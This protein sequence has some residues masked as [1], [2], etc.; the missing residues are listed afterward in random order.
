MTSPRNTSY[1]TRLPTAGESGDQAPPAEDPESEQ[2]A[3]S[4]AA[5]VDALRKRVSDTPLDKPVRVVARK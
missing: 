1:V 3:L 4:Y 2:R 5:L